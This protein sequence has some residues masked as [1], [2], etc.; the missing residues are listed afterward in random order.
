MS[1][2]GSADFN[3][4]NLIHYPFDFI[5]IIIA[6]FIFYVWGMRSRIITVSFGNAREVNNRVKK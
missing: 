1:Y 6:A 5:V 2:I 3:G 4:K